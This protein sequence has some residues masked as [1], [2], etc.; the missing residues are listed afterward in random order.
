MSTARASRIWPV[1]ILQL[2]VLGT[3]F[4]ATYDR[5]PL[6]ALTARVVGRD[7]LGEAQARAVVRSSEAAQ[8]TPVNAVQ[9]PDGQTRY[10]VVR[11]AA[12]P[13]EDSEL[14]H[15][16][17]GTRWTLIVLAALAVA[18]SMQSWRRRR[19]EHRDPRKVPPNEALDERPSRAAPMCRLP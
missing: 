14:R 4:A 6:P 18:A 16:R 7:R 3:G 17:S 5:G 8:R 12:P 15:A 2:A 1:L 10:A 11:S 19:R 9:R 13:A